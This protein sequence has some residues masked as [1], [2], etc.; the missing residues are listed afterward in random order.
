[1]QALLM[2]LFLISST[3]WGVRQDAAGDAKVKAAGSKSVRP[4]GDQMPKRELDFK[5]MMTG[6]ILDGTW[7]MTMGDPLKPDTRLT[8]PKPEKYTISK[9]DRG[10]EDYW[11]ITAR[12]QYADKDVEVPVMVRV[13]WSG[14]T[15]V[16]TVDNLPIP[17]IGTY[18]ARVMVHGGFYAGTWF[19]KGYGGVLSG[20]IF[21]K[22]RAERKESDRKLAPHTKEDTEE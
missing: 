12:I 18:S 20:K 6:A 13:V 1:M 11:I 21:H 16:I 3:T 19:G 9:V 7:Q 2:S 10:A 8:D 15:P 22:V 14:D 5:N 17:M 4:A